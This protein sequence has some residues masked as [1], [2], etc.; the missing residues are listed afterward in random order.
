[1]TSH[2]RTGFSRAWIGSVADA[3]IRRASTPVL[4]VRAERAGSAMREERPHRVVVPLDGSP[5]AREILPYASA[6]ASA[7]DVTLQLVRVITPSDIPD[8]GT[9]LAAAAEGAAVSEAQK[10]LDATAAQIAG[11]APAL[12]VETRALS[13]DSVA[14]AIIRTAQPRSR[15]VVAMTT[16]SR[17][18]ARLV[19]GSVADKVIRA[20]PRLVLLLRPR[21]G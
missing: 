12:V 4:L 10:E 11:A 2:G 16:R 20:G 9:D 8:V 7:L 18:L 21:H 14:E 5:A 13:A 3:I 1:M 15:V 6:V 19:V 17:G